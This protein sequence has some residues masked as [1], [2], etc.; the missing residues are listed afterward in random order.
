MRYFFSSILLLFFAVS[1]STP[2]TSLSLNT[3]KI[4]EADGK[5]GM[6]DDEG[7]VLI[8]AE[9]DHIGWSR[10]ELIPVNNTIGYRIA[11]KWGLISLKNQRITQAEFSRLYHTKGGVLVAGRKGKVTQHDFLGLI[12]TQ[13]KEIL[14][15][16]YTS[17]EVKGLRAVVSANDGR[18]YQYGVVDFSNKVVIPIRYKEIKPLGALRFAVKND[19]DKIA[20]YSD[21]GAQVVD[22]KLDSISNFSKGYASIFLNHQQ[23]LISTAG[24]LVV[25]PVYQSTRINNGE[26]EFKS[27]NTW[28][29]LN[30]KNVAGNTWNHTN[31][32]SYSGNKYLARSNGK[33]WIVDRKG[34]A[35][36][37][38]EN[39]YIG[40]VIDGKSSFRKQD[41]WGVLKV[42]GE[43]LIDAKFD[44]ILVDKDII[45]VMNK[46][47]DQLKWSLYD[48]F[49]I[50]KS[51]Y[52][53]D[54]IKA[55]TNNYYPVLRNGYWGFID[56]TGE[57]VIHCV[58]DEVNNFNGNNVV[59]KF[60]GDY[61]VVDKY[62]DW[63]VLPQKVRLELVNEDLY[64]AKSAK[65]TTLKSIDEGTIYFTE[66]KVEIKDGYLIEHLT[67]GNLWKINFSGRIVNENKSNGAKSSHLDKYQEI[68]SPSEGLYGVRINNL[69]GFIDNENRLLI[70]NR[71]E[72]VGPF[73]QG[74]AAIKLRNKW[75]FIDKSENLIVQPNYDLKSVFKD[76][77]AIVKYKGQYGLIN[78]EGKTLI[79]P[80]YDKIERLPNGRFLI[81]KNDRF[82]LVDDTGRL[83]INVKYESLEDLNNGQIIVEKFNQFGVIDLYGVDVIPIIYDQLKFDTRYNE[84][85][86][87]KKSKWEK[88]GIR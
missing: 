25:E 36:S 49:G 18:K 61:G 10:G 6:T 12:S 85:L 62:G 69:Y 44:S 17:V 43:V 20:I 22:F 55:K 14:P 57:E 31:L 78:N 19:Q 15:F 68:R 84:Y 82:G 16:K 21:Q 11:G 60:H 67:D 38:I 88:A 23:G 79:Q 56:R 29:A 48:T 40:P 24:E 34:T 83:I 65:L 59:V 46:K 4:F 71:Y 30:L 47:N 2:S 54:F 73:K 35:L 52:E 5:V 27:F 86:A 66:N 7:N 74:L 9:Y 50:K 39:N 8:P 37:S 28:T 33:T 32:T 76:N 51:S 81:S 64:L 63:K 42:H 70:S 26:V 75:G 53:Y 58:Y 41:K 13:G 45:Y 80:Q 77:L 1:F 72:D 3:Y 87:M